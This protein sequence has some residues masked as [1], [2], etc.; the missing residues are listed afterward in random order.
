MKAEW[1]FTLVL[2][3]GNRK[4]PCFTEWKGSALLSRCTVSWL[5]CVS[6]GQS[7]N[8]AWIVG[9]SWDDRKEGRVFNSNL[10]SLPMPKMPTLAVKT[11][12]EGKAAQLERL[13][14]HGETWSGQCWRLPVTHRDSREGSPGHHG[15][16]WACVSLN[17]RLGIS[18]LKSWRQDCFRVLTFLDFGIFAYM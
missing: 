12:Y 13:D 6:S 8:V 15:Q 3:A 11:I 10:E 9:R 14:L 17:Y 16:R 18:H 2:V 1:N 7:L 5:G 4:H